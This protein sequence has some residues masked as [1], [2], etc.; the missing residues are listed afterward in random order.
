MIEL[1][2]VT[3]TYPYADKAAL[4]NLSLTVRPGEAVLV[5]GVSGCGKST[6]IRLING[7][8]PHYY[9]GTVQGSITV[10]GKDNLQEK[11]CD[12]SHRVGTLFQNPES[13]FFALGV[14]EE[15]TFISE[16]KGLSAE[17]IQKRLGKTA[18]CFN[19]EH[20]LKQTIHELS[21]GQKQKVGLAS[22]MMEPLKA[23]IL[24]EPTGNLDPDA[25]LELAE[26]IKKLKAQGVAIV[27]ADHRLYW[28]KDVVDRV[29]VLEKGKVIREGHFSDLDSSFRE[30]HGLRELEVI[31]RRSIL[32]VRKA[33]KN[34]IMEISEL[35][36]SYP[37]QPEIIKNATLEFQQGICGIFGDNGT[38]KTTL[39]R[40]ITGLNK[41]KTGNFQIRGKKIK[42]KDCLKHVAV[43]L[44]NSDHQL[45]M[46]TVFEELRASLEAAGCK[47][48][49]QAAEEL[50]SI[51]DLQELKD[52]HPH[53]LSGGQ[54]Q[55][56]VIAC[57]FAK[58]PD[59]IILDE[60]TSGL[61]GANLKRVAGA[62]KK[63]SSEGKAVLV[64]THDLELVNLIC[65]T[66]IHL[67]LSEHT[68]DHSF[69]H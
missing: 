46:R 16:C 48:G 6:L 53:S 41:A 21:Q 23:L 15:I 3:Y 55:R 10:D 17:E 12:I 52:R 43:V 57:A 54:K 24:D 66:A 25:T 13:Q 39:A 37:H 44:Q 63:L 40:L 69:I 65:E 67:P 50:L 61:D 58:K 30:Q 22:L 11:L 7:L 33:S 28:L 29:M 32:P 35:S 4:E 1:K 2:N 20:L 26:E 49:N 42:Q 62:L 31:D 27:I 19:L 59:V 51:F 8:C 38:G 36:F 68:T 45:Y 64:I 18:K 14:E 60:P 5:T 9:G 56:L 47:G 34:P